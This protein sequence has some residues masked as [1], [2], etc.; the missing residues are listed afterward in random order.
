MWFLWKFGGKGNREQRWSLRI[1]TAIDAASRFYVES[2]QKRPFEASWKCHRYISHGSSLGQSIGFSWFRRRFRAGIHFGWLRR[3]SYGTSECNVF[4][5]CKIFRR[6]CPRFRN[7]VRVSRFC[8]VTSK[9]KK[10]AR[11]ALV[12]E[13][14]YNSQLSIRQKICLYDLTHVS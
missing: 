13:A 2:R 12:I 4:F 5:Y 9:V 11:T 6:R 1:D 3:P 14:H 7:S 8:I 10:I